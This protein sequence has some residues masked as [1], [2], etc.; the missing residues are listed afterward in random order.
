VQTV[1]QSV[2]ED[3]KK[4][5]SLGEI[6]FSTDSETE[7][8]TNHFFGIEFDSVRHVIKKAVRVRFD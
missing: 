4:N 8:E 6:D 2:L 7:T 5:K 3:N 1:R